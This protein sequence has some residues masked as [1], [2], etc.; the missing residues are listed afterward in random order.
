MSRTARIIVVLAAVACVLA[1]IGYSTFRPELQRAGFQKRLKTRVSPTELQAWATNLFHL[2][3][4]TEFDHA[5]TTNLHP[6]LR[7]LFIH[8]PYI[9]VYKAI[10]PDTSHVSVFYGGGGIGHWGIE[11][12]PPNRPT[13][14]NSDSRHYTEWAPGLCFFDGQ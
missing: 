1:F 10:P 2:A 14:A 9:A 5:T 13:P 12:G 8:E 7:G 4:E 11:I 6:A 3:D